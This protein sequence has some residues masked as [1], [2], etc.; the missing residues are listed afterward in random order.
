MSI[1]IGEHIEPVAYQGDLHA[2]QEARNYVHRGAIDLP[3]GHE[4]DGISN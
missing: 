1:A 2:E 3:N 4:A